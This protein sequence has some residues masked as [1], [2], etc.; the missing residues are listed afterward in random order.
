MNQTYRGA[1]SNAQCK[2]AFF[3]LDNTT[4]ELTQPL[5]GPS[6]WQDVLDQQGECIHHIAFQVTDTAGKARALAAKGIPLLHQGGDPQT[7]QFSYFDTRETLG[8]MIETLE[9]YK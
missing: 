5:G 8:L 3:E 6:S 7:G 4:I 2:L 1:P 9:G